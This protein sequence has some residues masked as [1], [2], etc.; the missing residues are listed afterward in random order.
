MNERKRYILF[1]LLIFIP[2][3]L[4]LNL[5]LWSFGWFYGIWGI[6]IILVWLNIFL[7]QIEEI[8]IER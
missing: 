3:L 7:R 1:N 4:V 6:A 8:V 2:T 5:Y